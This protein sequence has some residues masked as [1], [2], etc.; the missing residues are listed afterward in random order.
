ML[1]NVLNEDPMQYIQFFK[2]RTFL[3]WLYKSRFNVLFLNLKSYG[4]VLQRKNI[5]CHYILITPFVSLYNVKTTYFHSD[6]S[7]SKFIA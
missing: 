7:S 2:N 5:C 3:N 6:E 4:K 1:T